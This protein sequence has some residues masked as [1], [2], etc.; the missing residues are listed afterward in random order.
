MEVEN[1]V[2]PLGTLQ[3]VS[4]LSC[5]RS[6]S[7][8]LYA[9]NFLKESDIHKP[10]ATV[11]ALYHF[12]LDNNDSNLNE[13]K[14]YIAGKVG[15]SCK[16]KG[17]RDPNVVSKVLNHV[18]ESTVFDKYGSIE[19][20]IAYSS[21]SSSDYSL[22]LPQQLKETLHRVGFQNEKGETSYLDT[23]AVEQIFNDLIQPLI[24]ENKR[25]SSKP[26]NGRLRTKRSPL[27]RNLIARAKNMQSAVKFAIT[28]NIK[29]SETVIIN[30]LSKYAFQEPKQTEFNFVKDWA[31]TKFQ[32]IPPWAEE[33][34]IELADDF[35]KLKY[36]EVMGNKDLTAAD[37]TKKI[38]TL[39]PLKE[40]ADIRKILPVDKVLK[41][42]KR[43]EA[44]KEM[45]FEDYYALRWYGDD[46]FVKMHKPSDQERRMKN[47][48]YRLAIRQFETPGEQFAQQLFRGESRTTADIDQ[49]LADEKKEFEFN[50]F[51]STST[52]INKAI[53]Y[54]QNTLAGQTRVLYK[55]NFAE[56]IIRAKAN[57][58]LIKDENETILL[59]GTKFH[60]D[61]VVENTKD[62]VSQSG[63]EIRCIIVT[64]SSLENKSMILEREKSIMKKLKELAQEKTIYYVDL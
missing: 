46:G 11:N 47:A 5:M 20:F 21:M 17:A 41:D 22:R 2:N 3:M 4:I 1:F 19:G 57:H 33:L 40:N 39:Y 32:K 8:V 25:K 24:P 14:L 50:R 54:S 27:I 16:L 29:L 23:L 38:D 48:I 10:I 64:L 60:I 37:A 43:L 34:K 6:M 18:I 13:R 55:M 45:R 36:F 35:Y 51:T 12:L 31:N 59:P 9:E 58:L 30:E 44:F 49:V 7:D 63:D 53:E 52:D 61:S 28:S 26:R 56:P 15:T 42:F 62:C